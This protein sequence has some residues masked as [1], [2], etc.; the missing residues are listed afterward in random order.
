VSVLIKIWTNTGLIAVTP[1]T[2]SP[3]TLYTK[4]TLRSIMF[5]VLT[6]QPDSRLVSAARHQLC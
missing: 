1:Y 5:Y 2:S 4:I 6:S 3:A